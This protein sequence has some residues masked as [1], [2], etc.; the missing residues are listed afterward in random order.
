MRI[1]WNRERESLSDWEIGS[2][3]VRR[4]PFLSLAILEIFLSPS[5]LELPS[6]PFFLSLP[7]C[8]W[9]ELEN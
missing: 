3:D 9:R 2:R 6:L 5:H 8:R 4:N 7:F 1:E